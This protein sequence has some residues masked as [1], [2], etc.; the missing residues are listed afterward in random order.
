MDLASVAKRATSHQARLQGIVPSLQR[1][2]SDLF[3]S[4]PWKYVPGPWVMFVSLEAGDARRIERYVAILGASD[5]M[6][7][8]LAIYDSFSDYQMRPPLPKALAFMFEGG[9]KNAPKIVKTNGFSMIEPTI[10]DIEFLEGAIRPIGSFVLEAANLGGGGVEPSPT[11][12][13]PSEVFERLSGT[14]AEYLE[15]H[16]CLQKVVTFRGEVDVRIHLI[17]TDT[18]SIHLDT[19]GA[20]V[21]SSDEE[22][23]PLPVSIQECIV[24]S[25]TESDCRSVSGHGLLKCGGCNSKNERYCGSSCQKSDCMHALYKKHT[26]FLLFVCQFYHTLSYSLYIQTIRAPPQEDM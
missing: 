15:L 18:A 16:P 21:K 12:L 24:C 2:A 19:K 10:Q 1:A 4:A 13:S 9:K 5:K 22:V 20:R 23:T 14:T 11:P 17:P 26:Y 6:Q 7:R 25:K 8:G 3:E